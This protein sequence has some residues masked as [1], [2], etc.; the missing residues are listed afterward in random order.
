MKTKLAMMRTHKAF[1]QEIKDLLEKNGAGHLFKAL[2]EVFYKYIE[3][4][5]DRSARM[6]ELRRGHQD[7]DTIQSHQDREVRF[8]PPGR[9]HQDLV[10][11]KW[12][13]RRGHQDVVTGKGPPGHGHQIVVTKKWP[14]GRDRQ[15]VVTRKGLP[16]HGRQDV[17]TWKWPPGRGH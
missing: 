6:C 11:R 14:P 9:S 5:L 13:P 16:E 1:L 12:P 7:V 2:K 10:T 17:V 4:I 8:C 15:E 3:R